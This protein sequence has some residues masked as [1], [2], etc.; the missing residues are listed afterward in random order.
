M[1]FLLTCRK[2]REYYTLH[3]VTSP[4]SKLFSLFGG[5]FL[6]RTN[7]D[8]SHRDNGQVWSLN[9]QINTI[10]AK[11][12]SSFTRINL[13]SLPVCRAVCILARLAQPD[14]FIGTRT[15]Q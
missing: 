6:W 5:L 15:R 14:R 7:F 3:H 9:K 1:P 13:F 12:L 2:P 10:F 4:F 11:N 8:K